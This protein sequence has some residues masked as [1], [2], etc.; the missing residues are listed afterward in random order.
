MQRLSTQLFFSTNFLLF[1]LASHP[2]GQNYFEDPSWISAFGSLLLKARWGH[3]NVAKTYHVSLPV[4]V[5]E[6]AMYWFHEL[7]KS[8]F[9]P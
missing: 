6:E 3:Q 9:C 7:A 4:S 5:P 8:G 1:L 2:W